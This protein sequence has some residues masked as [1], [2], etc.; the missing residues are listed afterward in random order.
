MRIAI[1]TDGDMVSRHFGRCSHYTIIDVNGRNV[2]K[3]EVVE[4]PGH[5]PNFLP[6]FLNEKEV[7]CILT[8]GM[9]RKARALFEQYDIE[10]IVGVEGEIEHVID[11]I[12]SNEL[13]GS[14]NLCAPKHD[15][16]GHTECDH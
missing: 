8:G 11:R 1:A 7:D 9:G 2:N 3:R 13:E 10:A 4:N 16:K 12:L 15:H 5:Q 6:G 14:D